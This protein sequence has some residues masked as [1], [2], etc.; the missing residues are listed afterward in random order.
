MYNQDIPV[1]PSK[2]GLTVIIKSSAYTLDIILST[3]IRAS[4]FIMPVF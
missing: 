1:F 4:V 2:Q 3:A